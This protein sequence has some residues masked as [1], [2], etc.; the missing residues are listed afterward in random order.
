MAAGEVPMM[1]GPNFTAVKRAQKKDPRGVLQY[2]SLEPVPVRLV[3]EEVFT[4]LPAT[5]MQ[6][7][8]G[9]NGWQAMKLRN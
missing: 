1:I 8:C 7:C 9:S 2:V 6:R 5:P 4:R 3:V